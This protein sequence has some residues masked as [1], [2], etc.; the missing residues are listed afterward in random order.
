MPR[1]MGA[2]PGVTM[3]EE[4]LLDVVLLAVARRDRKTAIKTLRARFDVSLKQARE[5]VDGCPSLLAEGVEW[6]D[7]HALL[8]ELAG[9]GL[10]VDY[11]SGLARAHEV[12]TSWVPKLR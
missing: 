6:R 5:L 4:S 9:E 10:R 11:G 1:A 7:A 2:A 3:G 12:D 8:E